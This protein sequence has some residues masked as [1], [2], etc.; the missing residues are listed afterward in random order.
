[1]PANTVSFQE[2]KCLLLKRKIRLLRAGR[3]HRFA[4]GLELN[5]AMIEVVD[6]PDR[7]GPSFRNIQKKDSCTACAAPQH[8]RFF[9][10]YRVIAPP[11]HGGLFSS[12]FALRS[13][14]AIA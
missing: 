5:S 11:A 8:D 7:V 10:E 14:S 9:C 6:L 3:S 1:M 4:A 12:W 2:A 13:R